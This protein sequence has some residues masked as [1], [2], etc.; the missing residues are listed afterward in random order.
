ML[1]EAPKSPRFKADD[2]TQDEAAQHIQGAWRT[3]VARARFKALVSGVWSKGYDQKRGSF[4][5]YNKKSGESSWEKP[6]VLHDI[7][8]DLTPRSELE[9]IKA[10]K[11]IAKPKTPR[12]K[13]SD[14]TKDAA[15]HHSTTMA[16][17]RSAPWCAQH[18]PN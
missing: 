12:F 5:Y 7:D 16:T 13:A 4:F 18:A 2:L 6:A 1:V 17:P 9:A 3:S 8:V 10:R 14:L 11:L 15:A